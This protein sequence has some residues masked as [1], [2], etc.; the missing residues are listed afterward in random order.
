MLRRRAL[1]PVAEEE[2]RYL[3]TTRIE[4]LTDGVFAIVM[5]LLVL[6]L[7]VPDVRGGHL[8]DVLLHDWPAY[9]S[10]A[11]SFVMLGVYW[12][13]H[14]VQCNSIR[15]ADRP[16][17]WLNLLFLFLVSLVPFSTALLGKYWQVPA[18]PTLYGLH[19]MAI[20]S[21]SYGLWSYATY[22]HRLVDRDISPLLV[23]LVKR[24][25]LLT[26][27]VCAVAIALSWFFPRLSLLLYIFLPAYYILP[28]KIDVFWARKAPIH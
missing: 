13:S 21:V 6:E 14:H 22:R 24:R 7:E 16:F 15:F 9:A 2:K 4:T 3:S 10:Y 11:I 20:G 18:L 27:I 8:I 12:V 26:P 28:G 19:L 17:L 25:V 1:P 23:G 5:T